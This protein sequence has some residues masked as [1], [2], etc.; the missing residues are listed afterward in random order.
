MPIGKSLALAAVLSLVAA[1]AHASARQLVVQG[2]FAKS[3]SSRRID[4]A[5]A[6]VA[7]AAPVSQHL[8]LAPKAKLPSRRAV[9][10]AQTHK[11]LPVL[12]R[13]AGVA[14]DDAGNA[15]FAVI[16]LEENLPDDTIPRITDAQAALK[17]KTQVGLDTKP[18]DARL[19]VFPTPAGARLAWLVVPSGRVPTVPYAPVLVLD[20]KTGE[21][22]VRWNAVNAAQA[23]VYPANPISTP[24]LIEVDLPVEEGTP[25][26]VNS[27]IRSTNCVDRGN[28]RKIQG[29]EVRVC[30]VEQTAFPDENGDFLHSPGED[31][32]PEDSFAEISLF[33]H[34][35]RAYDYFVGLGMAEL[36]SRLITV[37]NLRLA[38]ELVTGVPDSSGELVPF[39]NAFYVGGESVFSQLFDAPPPALFFGQGPLRDYSYDGDIVYHEFGHAV[40]DNT[41]EFPFWYHTDEQGLSSAPGAMN[42]GLADYFAAVL[43]GD[44]HMGE[45]AA[46]DL[47]LGT[48]GIRDLDGSDKCPD[49]LVGEVHSDSVFFSSALWS[50]RRTLHESDRP[51]FDQAVFDVLLTAP[52]GDLGF[53]D[54][55]ELLLASVR[56]SE[57]GEAGS[58]LAEEALEARGVLPS[59]D[60][61]ITWNGEP[62]DSKD[63]TTDHTFISPGLNDVPIAPLPY[64]PGIVQFRVPLEPT[65]HLAVSFEGV[66]IEGVNG[67]RFRPRVLVRWGEEPIAF[68]WSTFGANSDAQLTAQSM[69]SSNAYRAQTKVPEG[70]ET[71]HV[72]V[73]N[74]G[75][76]QG[77]Y[78]HVHFEF[79]PVDE[80]LPPDIAAS[81]P[82][83]PRSSDGGCAITLTGS[84][85]SSGAWLSGLL[86]LGA[87]ALRRRRT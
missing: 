37:S 18:S 51:L 71:A 46:G 10:L 54:F 79:Q 80:G 47:Q 61:R 26:L 59:C 30:E 70:V 16:R 39:Q 21:T 77:I 69:A 45:Y 35:N 86:V 9:E 43:T 32:D 15:R 68:E 34:A 7:K 50:I 2:P 74:A 84:S 19:V 6:I 12:L 44:P 42:E 23:R 58:K 87:A 36:K 13:G 24:N 65:G 82:F 25:A 57:L 64:A 67:A 40:A 78:R 8:E 75:E 62:I 83:V 63:P 4:Q 29:T 53:D 76:Q 5:R 33:H 31:D 72:M 22:I 28:R 56:S 52:S 11:G 38:S 14:F 41:I 81:D 73:V 27:R 3:A 55:A 48:N 17:A 66:G 85:L 60:R 20:A 49:N 1:E